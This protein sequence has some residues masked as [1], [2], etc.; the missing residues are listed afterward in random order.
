MQILEN[1]N[2]L[3]TI[4]L[5]QDALD[6]KNKV[7]QKSSQNTSSL[8]SGGKDLTTDDIFKIQEKIRQE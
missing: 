6:I 1:W 4:P 7:T 8:S 5:S 3:Q 2:Q